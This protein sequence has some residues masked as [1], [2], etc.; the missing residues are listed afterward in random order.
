MTKHP[1]AYSDPLLSIFAR[2]LHGASEVLDPMAG[3]GKLAEIK[4][5]FWPGRVVCNELEREWIDSSPY[6]VDEWHCGDAADMAWCSDGRFDAVCT[7]P[8]YGNRMAD[9]HEVHEDSVHITYRHCLG[10]PLS[11]GNTGMMQWGEA[12]RA[13]HEAIYRE[14]RRVL[15]KGG[16]L[17]VNVSDHIRKGA[18]VPVARWHSDTIETL[19]FAEQERIEVPTKRMRWGKNCHLR[20]G[21]EVVTSFRRTR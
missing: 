8:T 5:H 3:T 1:A 16:L 7:S 13:K 15:K 19:G 6:L 10:R 20:V 9:H 11:G 4:A 18:V 21:Y 17:I 14:I 2:M 12:Y